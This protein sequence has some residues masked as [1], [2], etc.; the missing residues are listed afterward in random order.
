[1]KKKLCSEIS[2]KYFSGTG[3]SIFTLNEIRE[4][5][6]CFYLLKKYLQMKK[7]FALVFRKD[8]T[9]IQVFYMRL[10]IRK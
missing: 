8:V 9:S 6:L 2:S 1:M 3:Y 7:V 5:G 4:T 10:Q